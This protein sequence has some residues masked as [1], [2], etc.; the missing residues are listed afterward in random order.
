MFRLEVSDAIVKVAKKKK[1]D[2]KKDRKLEADVL[3]AV[4]FSSLPLPLATAADA[5]AH[6]ASSGKNRG[7]YRK[8]IQEAERR[9]IH[10]RKAQKKSLLSKLTG[11]G[12]SDGFQITTPDLE[13]SFQ[14]NIREGR[15]AYDYGRAVE[16]LH[17]PE[18]MTAKQLSGKT[19]MWPPSSESPG[20]TAHELG[21]A[22]Q[23]PRS[24]ILGG[25]LMGLGGAGALG[26]IYGAS[27]AKTPEEAQQAALIGTGL[28]A[29]PGIANLGREAGA[30]VR[31][32]RTLSRL[33]A[34]RGQMLSTGLTEM[35]PS[36]LSSAG[37]ASL[38]PLATYLTAK[39][40]SPRKKKKKKK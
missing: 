20:L 1:E 38:M 31:G 30:H 23:K 27:K 4:L 5:I 10:V 37:R 24:G 32:L 6:R 33:G 16:R 28:S 22:E 34:T 13:P 21:H 11:G 29:I 14:K 35:L 17:D 40:M 26:G 2:T 18:V 3:K 36:F 12:F 8:V 15:S 9:G 7:L 25:L 19:V 39:A